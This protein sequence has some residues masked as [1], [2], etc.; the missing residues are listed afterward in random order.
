[1]FF[2]CQ[3][4]CAKWREILVKSRR[5]ARV[6]SLSDVNWH[7]VYIC[8]IEC[9]KKNNV[10]Y[11]MW[12]N[13]RPRVCVCAYVGVHERRTVWGCW[14]NAINLFWLICI[15]NGKH[16]NFLRRSK[17]SQVQLYFIRLDCS[18]QSKQE[19]KSHSNNSNH[20]VLTLALFWN[21]KFVRHKKMPKMGRWAFQCVCVCVSWV[22][23]QIHG[24]E[25]EMF[26]LWWSLLWIVSN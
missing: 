13:E 17:A 10:N 21:W 2:W 7:I 25:R 9:R 12:A 5:S 16:F 23:V 15:E 14:N 24:G 22:N 20:L 18:I 8:F 11:V 26:V 1:M 19:E 4:K 6:L 3:S